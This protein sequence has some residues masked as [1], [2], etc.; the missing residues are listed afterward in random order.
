[1]EY[2]GGCTG[3]WYLHTPEEIA[4]HYQEELEPGVLLID[5]RPA[6]EGERGTHANAYASPMC[7]VELPDGAI[8]RLD[9]SGA[10]FMVGALKQTGYGG[11]L[12]AHEIAAEVAPDVAGPLDS[13][14]ISQYVQWWRDRG[15]AIYRYDGNEFQP[16]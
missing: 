3:S 2:G 7:D 14:S 16:V 10:E 9:L 11:I 4:K 8:D 6:L 1:M 12:R 13:V 5:K 15:A